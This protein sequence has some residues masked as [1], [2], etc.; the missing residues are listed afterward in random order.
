MAESLLDVTRGPQIYISAV[1]ESYSEDR[2]ICILHPP[3][4]PQ[5]ETLV[6][7]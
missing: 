7:Q 3:L 6:G 1:S 4:S 5:R 2:Q